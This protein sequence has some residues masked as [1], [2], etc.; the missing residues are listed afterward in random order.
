VRRLNLT[1]HGL[2][3]PP[4]SISE[5]EA[6]VWVDAED[7][8]GTLDRVVGNGNV[9]LTFD[10]GNRSDVD[11]ALPAL[12]ERGLTATFFV[13]ALRIGES[14][15][16]DQEAIRDLARA[17]MRI[18]S[19]GFAHRDW[20]ALND[21]ALMDEL[22]VSRRRLE[23]VAGDSVSRAACPFGSYDRRVLAM[24]RRTGYERVYTSDGGWTKEGSWLQS[25]NTLRYSEAAT[26]AERLLRGPGVSDRVM[27]PL[28]QAVKRSR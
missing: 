11:V 8:E 17:G 15:Y 18:G 14:G 16:L 7:F 2:G 22:T 6:S 1:F 9:R 12:L 5:S 27:L 3:S 28:R 25:R 24:L 21:D 10:D 23:V 26:T 20:R 4:E 13:V 19:H